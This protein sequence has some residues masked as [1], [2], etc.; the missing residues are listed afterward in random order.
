MSVIQIV[1]IVLLALILIGANAAMIA[2][3]IKDRELFDPPF[4]LAILTFALDFLLLVFMIA[5]ALGGLE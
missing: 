4:M 1:C 3:Y 5:G 2:I